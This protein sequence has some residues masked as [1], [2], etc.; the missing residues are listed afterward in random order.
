[1]VAPC[2]LG[3]TGQAGEAIV[4]ALHERVDEILTEARI[5]LPGAQALLGFQ[6]SIV[7]TEG[8]EG[9]RTRP[10]WFTEQRCCWLR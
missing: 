9:C 7:V 6:L 10:S 3:A 4:Q 5:I 2:Q 8:F 1:M